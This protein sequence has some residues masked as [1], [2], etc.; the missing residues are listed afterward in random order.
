MR[1]LIIEDDAETARYIAKGL[2]ESGYAVDI[3]TDGKEGLLQAVGED[4]DVAVVD[5]MLPGLDGL[6][7]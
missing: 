7:V 1:V 5:R 3:V 2:R 4:Y 6:S